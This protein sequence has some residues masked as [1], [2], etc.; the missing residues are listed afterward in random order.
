MTI[1][2]IRQFPYDPWVLL[3]VPLDASDADVH[4]AWKHAGAP[5]KGPLFLAKT[6][7][8]NSTSRMKTQLLRTQAFESPQ[9]AAET[10]P[11]QPCYRGSGPWYEEIHRR[12]QSSE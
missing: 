11:L 4:R 3:G 12:H 6:M 2:E 7:L 8:A 10:L 1:Q 9:K 5:Q